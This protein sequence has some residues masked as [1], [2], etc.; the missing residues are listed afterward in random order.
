[1]KL[2]KTCDDVYIYS[3]IDRSNI[4]IYIHRYVDVEHIYLHGYIHLS[5]SMLRLRVRRGGPEGGGTRG[6]ALK[7][8]EDMGEMPEV[9]GLAL[10]HPTTGQDGEGGLSFTRLLGASRCAS[11]HD[12]SIHQR[13]VGISF[14][15]RASFYAP[16]GRL[17]VCA[18]WPQAALSSLRVLGH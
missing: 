7:G 3:Y 14:V 12:R 13:S 1:M 9:G 17:L 5:R 11:Q 15:C 6:G 16:A 18:R 2:C 4:A 8:T 10:L